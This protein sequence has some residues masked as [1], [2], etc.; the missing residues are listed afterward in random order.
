MAAGRC[1]ARI[2]VI[3]RHRYFLVGSNHAETKYHVLKIDRTEPK[4]LVFS[5][6][7]KAVMLITKRRKMADIG[8]HALYKVEDT[9][10]ICI[11]NDSVRITDPDEAS[12]SYDLSHSLQYNLTS[13]SCEC[14]W[15]C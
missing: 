1:R 4:D 9:N 3:A 14:P 12:Y 10:M 5:V 2:A 11:P 15:G 13:W 7:W 6:S 8:G